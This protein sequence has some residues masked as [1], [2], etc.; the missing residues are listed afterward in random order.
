MRLLPPCVLAALALAAPAGAQVQVPDPVPPQPEPTVAE[1]VTLA[2]VDV[3][4]QTRAALRETIRGPVGDRVREPVVLRGGGRE[5]RL[6]PGRIGLRVVFERTLDRTM[7]AEP[8]TAVRPEVTFRAR[9]IRDFL[10]RFAPRVAVAPVDARIHIRL[11]RIGQSRGRPGRRLDFKPATRRIKAALR[12]PLR[13]RT[14]RATFAKVRP[15]VGPRELKDRYP[16][17]ITIDQ[18]SF[19]L[20]LFR[21]LR[22][23]RS[24]SVAV[25]QPAYPTPNGLFAI[26]SKQV[27]PTWTAPNSPWA[28]EAAGQSYD[29]SDPN[30]P[31]KARWMG[32]SGSVGIHGTGEDSSIGTRASHGCIRMRVG[33]VI[34]LYDRVQIG[35][36]V[37]IAP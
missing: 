21:R 27:N 2:G 28:G 30:N 6:L 25:G 7:A 31:L 4:G 34:H 29:S 35:T 15:A 12:A 23:S 20:R 33:D 24:Y 37:L 8:Y 14:V 26:Q 16:S 13:P 22:Y 5:G 10:G 9:A 32:V 1:G 18:S 17:I 11:T 36:P 3:A 19:T